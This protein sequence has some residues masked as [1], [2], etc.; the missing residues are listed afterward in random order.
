MVI[1]SDFFLYKF[2][3][4]FSAENSTGEGEINISL[5]SGI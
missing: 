3:L 1:D 2:G 4:Q 5:H